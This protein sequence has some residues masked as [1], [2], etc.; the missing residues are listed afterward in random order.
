MNGKLQNNLNKMK[1][2]LPIKL[3]MLRMNSKNFNKLLM[4]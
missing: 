3:L 4:K 1:N 2:N